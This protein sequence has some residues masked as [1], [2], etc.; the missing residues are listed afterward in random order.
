MWCSSINCETALRCVTLILS[1]VPLTKYFYA[2]QALL[3]GDRQKFLSCLLTLS[4]VVDPETQVK[5]NTIYQKLFSS[6]KQEV[7]EN[8]VS[9]I[10]KR[11]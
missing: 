10:C 5:Q 11:K 8:N 9:F 2:I 1:Y 3:I 4:V 7:I 6:K